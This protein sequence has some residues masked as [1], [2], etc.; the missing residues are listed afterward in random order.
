MSERTI[1]P[2]Q[3]DA[4]T[5]L[6]NIMDDWK[7]KDKLLNGLRKS[8]PDFS[9]FRETLLSVLAINKFYNAGCP[10][11]LA[12]AIFIATQGSQIMELYHQKMSQDTRIAR[13][14][15]VKRIAI[16][17]IAIENKK[18][19]GC[20]V[21][22]SK[23]AHFFID[24]DA[25]PILDKNAEKMVAY[26]HSSRELYRNLIKEEQFDRGKRYETFYDFFHTLIDN[27]S[28]GEDKP[29]NKV[30]DQYLWLA[31]ICE[32][33]E[34]KDNGVNPEVKEKYRSSDAEVKRLFG[35]LFDHP[36]PTQEMIE[37]YH[38]EKKALSGSRRN[39]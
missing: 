38:Q 20:P 33:L 32:K 5:K 14:E 35:D 26:H 34:L 11:P 23:F 13:I 6:Y 29:S 3:I 19:D 8:E 30:F 25:F 17:D 15:L 22:T 24:P 1:Q 9:N 4:A 37:N 31:G 27:P 28:Y 18:K 36:S 16:K 10:D 12:M 21:F 7:C 2:P 39:S